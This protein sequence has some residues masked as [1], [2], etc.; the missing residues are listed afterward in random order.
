MARAFRRR[1]SG[2]DVRYVAH[3]DADER[4]VVASLME[5][6]RGMLDSPDAPDHGDDEFGGIVAG[7]GIGRGDPLAGHHGDDAR[8]E[9]PDGA[10][11]ARDPALDRLLPSGNREDEQAAAEFRRLTEPGLRHRKALALDAAVAALQVDDTV[12]LDEGA[13]RG[14]LTA[15]TD[16]RLVLGERLQLRTDE[17]LDLLEELARSLDPEDPVV[18]AVELYDFLTWIQE[19]LASALLGD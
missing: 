15:L 19:T 2:D 8:G 14:F 18:H 12:R 7:L 3:L 4:E 1:G 13:A 11:E 6:V 17:D 5:Q 16:V 9:V 10:P